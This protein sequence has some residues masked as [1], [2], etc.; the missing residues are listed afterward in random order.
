MSKCPLFLV[1]LALTVG[2]AGCL[3]SFGVNGDGGAGTGGSGGNNGST[4]GTNGGGPKTDASVPSTPDMATPPDMAIDPVQVF[5]E[6][7]APIVTQ[8]C[9]GCHNQQGGIG[10]GFLAPDP[11]ILTTM[12]AYPGLIGPT[13]DT[14]RIYVKGAHEGP[15]LSPVD[16]P[17]VGNWITLWNATR[18]K[19]LDGGVNKPTVAP[20]APIIGSNSI[21]LSVIDPSLAGQKVT[22]TAKMVGTTLEMTNIMI[23]A[24]PTMGIHVAHPLWVMWDASMNPTPD[25]VDSF[26]NLDETVD[27]GAALAMGPGILFLPNFSSTM[28]LNVVFATVE[29]KA[30]TGDGGT[31]LIGCKSVATW[32]SDA[33][34]PLANNCASCHGGSNASATSA[35]PLNGASDTANCGNTLGEVNVTTPA[36]G[37][38]FSYPNPAN[39]GN[40]HPFHFPDTTTYNTFTTAVGMWIANEK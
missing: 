11:D 19:V 1:T 3:P 6:Q 28:M 24:A 14:S 29:A 7:V 16:K 25:P 17:I 13:P 35:F 2:A 36:N 10:P 27:D 38:L 8:A 9:A 21:D 5:N 20:F 22:F 23:S 32:T 34:T 40:G 4:G 39:P 37:N 26:A 18:P 30:V 12:L 33:K 31:G 15:A